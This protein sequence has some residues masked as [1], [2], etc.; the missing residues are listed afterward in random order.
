MKI[1]FITI[2][3]GYIVNLGA[4]INKYCLSSYKTHQARKQNPRIKQIGSETVINGNVAIGDNTY[5][6]GGHFQ[7]L[8][9]SSITIGNN[10]MISYGVKMRTDT[11]IHK[12]A[13]E[14]MIK[15]GH[16][17]KNITIGNDVWIGEDAYIM[18]GVTIG[19]GAIVGARAV[20]TKD[21]EKY[22]VVAGVPA[23]IINKRVT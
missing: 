20:V 9:N 15:Q 6:N 18:P 1:N 22:S 7:A 11:H 21:V 13:K 10:C 14:P 4:R 8:K 5:I 19:D 23:K 16:E 17:Y 12:D 3:I 2:T